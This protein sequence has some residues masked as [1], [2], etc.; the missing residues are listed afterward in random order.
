MKTKILIAMAL[1][2]QPAVFFSTAAE[3]PKSSFAPVMP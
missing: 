3:P 2:L 1:V